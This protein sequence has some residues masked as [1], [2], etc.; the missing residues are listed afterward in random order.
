MIILRIISFDYAAIFIAIILITI[1][2]LKIK[3]HDRNSKLYLLILFSVLLASILNIYADYLIGILTCKNITFVWIIVTLRWLINSYIPFWVLVYSMYLCKDYRVNKKDKRNLLLIFIADNI[4]II[5]SQFTK[6]CFYFENNVYYES[7]YNILIIALVFME[8]LYTI[9]QYIDV[10]ELFSK[11]Q[12][13]SVKLVFFIQ[14]LAFVLQR[15]LRNDVSIISFIYAVSLFVLFNAVHMIEWE[16]DPVYGVLNKNSFIQRINEEKY[17]DNDSTVIAINF[18]S[19]D[20]VKELFGLEESLALIK[21]FV[22]DI[23]NI[24]DKNDIY[25]IQDYIFFIISDKI[26]A[27]DKEF[28][29]L[30]NISSNRKYQRYKISS[31]TV[32]CKHEKVSNSAEEFIDTI[33]SF[34][35]ENRK[36][37]DRLLILNSE[38]LNLKQK[39]QAILNY[40]QKVINETDIDLQFQPIYNVK[41]NIFDSCEVLLRFTNSDYNY[42]IQDFVLVCEENELVAEVDEIILNKV[43]NFI[44]ENKEQ[45]LNVKRFDVNLSALE[46][47]DEALSKRLMNKLFV[48]GIT[49]GKISFELTETANNIYASNINKTIKE[50]RNH[51][52]YFA[53]DDFGTGYSSIGSLFAYDFDIVKLDK[54]FLKD[55]FKDEKRMLFFYYSVKTLQELKLEICLEGVETQDEADDARRLGIDF[56]QGYYYSKPLTSKAYLAFLSRQREKAHS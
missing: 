40:A 5:T 7:S 38:Y 15:F 14:A 13:L 36:L 28:V 50:L 49:D 11:Y 12:L 18:K 19:F 17:H 26:D 45:L 6:L 35:I 47:V 22:Q 54:T 43:I 56:I 46:F 30:Q 48:N 34:L 10:K 44:N 33:T 37:N 20:I 41:E 51:K 53:L 52:I 3:R 27:Y 39:K 25:H 1:Y 2:F 24:Y 31:Q 42:S 55:I 29:K 4:F 32:V 9:K 8:M 16:F 23:K 21:L